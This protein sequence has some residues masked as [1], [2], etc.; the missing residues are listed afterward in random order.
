MVNS[1]GCCEFAAMAG[2]NPSKPEAHRTSMNSN[3]TVPL[4]LLRMLTFE[5]QG[6]DPDERKILFLELLF[7][8]LGALFSRS[9]FPRSLF[10]PNL[11]LFDEFLGPC[12]DRIPVPH[13]DT[14]PAE[15][16]L[17][18]ISPLL[19]AVQTQVA[20]ELALHNDERDYELLAA[21]QIVPIEELVRFRNW[22]IDL[23]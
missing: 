14:H 22:I 8:S 12:G 4:L 3:A 19:P 2:M 23:L 17:P 6:R 18:S 15:I 9:S 11:V 10:L 16:H 13:R 20:T 21:I 5:H 1:F 7:R